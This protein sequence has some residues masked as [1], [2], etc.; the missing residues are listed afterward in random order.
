MVKPICKDTFVLSM[1][2]VPATK[3]D[4]Q[5]AQDLL[6]TLIANERVCVGMAAN[7]IGINKSIIVFNTGFKNIVMFNPVIKEQSELYEASEGCLCHEGEKKVMRYK[8][9]TVEYQDMNFKRNVSKYTGWV[10]EIIQHEIDHLNG[11]LI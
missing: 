1:K 8:N 7:M 9:I 10:A 4:K 6:E 2:A 5:I 11:I 3:A